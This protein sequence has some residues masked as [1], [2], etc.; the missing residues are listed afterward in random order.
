M[1]NRTISLREFKLFDFMNV[2]TKSRLLGCFK[3]RFKNVFK[4]FKNTLITFVTKV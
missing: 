1:I 2:I 4:W 3:L